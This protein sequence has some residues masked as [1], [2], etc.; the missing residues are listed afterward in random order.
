MRRCG[1]KPPLLRIAAVLG[2]LAAAFA[3]CTV[4]VAR[5]D[6]LTEAISPDGNYVVRVTV[7]NHVFS[8]ETFVV[9]RD[10]RD[11][12]RFGRVAS[13]LLLQIEG[14]AA[15]D[16]VEVLWQD[17]G[18][19]IIEYYAYAKVDSL[20]DESWHGISFIIRK[21]NAPARS[22]PKEGISSA[23]RQLLG[24]DS[25]LSDQSCHI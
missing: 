18:N 22:S 16:T 6:V 7:E 20:R 19:L 1:V 21:R 23:V 15:K 24:E 13:N 14:R 5:E 17:Q 9:V 2:L 3:A 25:K 12:D 10:L 8:Y 4:V 11:I